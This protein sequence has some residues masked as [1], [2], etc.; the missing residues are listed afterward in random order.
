[1]KSSVY[2]SVSLIKKQIS[3]FILLDARIASVASIK[4]NLVSGED[5]EP[6]AIEIGLV[7]EIDASETAS[8]FNKIS[9]HLAT[10]DPTSA[11]APLLVNH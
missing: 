3:A 4:E 11:H 10:V 7:S 9:I 1:M 5:N 6:D 8:I 2:K